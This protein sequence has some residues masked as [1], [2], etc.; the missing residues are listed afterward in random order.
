MNLGFCKGDERDD[1][2]DG[3]DKEKTWVHLGGNHRGA[4]DPGHFGGVYYSGDAGVY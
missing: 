4:G 3:M 2:S 1:E